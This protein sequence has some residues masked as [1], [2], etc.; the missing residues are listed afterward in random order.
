MIKNEALKWLVEN[1]TRW[2]TS[3]R[4]IASK[5]NG[6]SWADL[7][8]DI[9]LV[10]DIPT[11]MYVDCHIEQKEWLDYIG[12]SLVDEPLPPLGIY[13]I[14]GP[15]T[16]LPDF[17]RSNFNRKADEITL[18]GQPVLNP[19]TLP[20]GLSHVQ[21]MSICLPMVQCAT[22]M[23]MLKGWEKSPGAL[24]EHALAV[25]LKLEISYE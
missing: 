20:D 18:S 3:K 15:M 7:Q 21:Y 4:G 5:P 24:A 16:G 6:W 22:H 11:E 8:G 14:A 17:N 1:V 23:Y 2:P 10:R 25:K 12:E 19:A 9:C 13:Y